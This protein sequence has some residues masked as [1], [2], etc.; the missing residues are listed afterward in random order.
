MMKSLSRLTRIGLRGRPIGS[1][2]HRTPIVTMHFS[3]TRYLGQPFGCL[4]MRTW[5]P[6]A[7]LVL[8]TQYAGTF[9]LRAQARAAQTSHRLG[10]APT[11]VAPRTDHKCRSSS[12]TRAPPH[13]PREQQRIGAA[14]QQ[15]PD[16]QRSRSTVVDQS[17][18][19]TRM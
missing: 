9:V 17:G 6:G 10:F 5:Q 4:R 2:A 19:L 15:A 3:A 7:T 13:E 16:P 11:G 14:I 12:A 8:G 1:P 18:G